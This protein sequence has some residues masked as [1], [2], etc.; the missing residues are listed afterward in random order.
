MENIFFILKKFS[1]HWLIYI[2]CYN[3]TKYNKFEHI[4]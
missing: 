1:L 4:K 3:K 2:A